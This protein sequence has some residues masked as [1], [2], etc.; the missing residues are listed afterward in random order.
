MPEAPPRRQDALVER[1]PRQRVD[2]AD[3]RAIPLRRQQMGLDRPLD[4]RQ[5]RLLVEVRHLGPERERHLLPD[6]RG[7]RQRLAHLLAEPGH[8]PVDHL[9]Q[10]GRHDDAV[11]FA[12]RPPVVTL[13]QQRFLLQGAQELGGEER[14]ALGVLLQVGDEARFVR[15]RETVRAATRATES[16]RVEPPQVEPQPIRLA[17]QRRQLLG[18]GMARVSSS[19]R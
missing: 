6:H 19:T 13:P 10:E 1:L 15:G 12:E 7:H 9:A 17:H 2:E 3:A 4:D 5:Q 14:V 8:P 18:E 11:E 16:L